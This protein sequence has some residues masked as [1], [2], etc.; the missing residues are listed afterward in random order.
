MNIY[1]PSQSAAVGAAALA[2]TAVDGLYRGLLTAEAL[3]LDTV[4]RLCL[5]QAAFEA[6]DYYISVL[7]GTEVPR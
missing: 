7:L 6:R 1:N 2:L 3:D 5:R 4:E